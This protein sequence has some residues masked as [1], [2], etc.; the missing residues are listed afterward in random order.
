MAHL[1]MTETE[2]RRKLVRQVEMNGGSGG[3]RIQTFAGD[4]RKA[5]RN[6][7][8]KNCG[9]GWFEGTSSRV[10]GAGG[11]PSGYLLSGR[12]TH[13]SARHFDVVQ[14]LANRRSDQNIIRAFARMRSR[15]GW[16]PTSISE[17]VSARLYRH[18]ASYSN[19]Y[20]QTI[21]LNIG[22]ETIGAYGAITG[23]HGELC[24]F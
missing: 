10:C 4:I 3:G 2:S 5:D 1:Y 20:R 15:L 16:N 14:Q 23:D 13:G 18:A 19:L 8:C 17:E 7:G 24:R 22:K 12:S 11:Q 21:Q 6:E 9:E